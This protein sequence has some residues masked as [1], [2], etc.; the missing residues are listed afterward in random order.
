[1]GLG[2]LTYTDNVHESIHAVADLEEQVLPLPLGRGAERGPHQP[3]D[4]G[5][6]EQRAQDDGG[7]L[8]LLDHRQGNGLPLEERGEEDR[9]RGER[10]RRQGRDA[11]TT[12]HETY[13]LATAVQE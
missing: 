1:M 2:A 7:N 6:E 4:A 3:R 5:D 8:D 12:T 10:E 11:K 9:R 13:T